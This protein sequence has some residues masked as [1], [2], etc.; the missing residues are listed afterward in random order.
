MNELC[1]IWFDSRR[2]SFYFLDNVGHLN[3]GN[4]LF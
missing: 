2:F 1:P 4:V 3:E